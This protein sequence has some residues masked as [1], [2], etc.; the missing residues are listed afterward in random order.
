MNATTPLFPKTYLFIHLFVCFQQ[1]Y[2]PSRIVWV[3][4]CEK[5]MKNEVFKVGG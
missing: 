5:C 4:N 2:L 3:N 1:T